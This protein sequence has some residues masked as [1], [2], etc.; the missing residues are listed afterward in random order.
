LF[1]V[2]SV[3]HKEKRIVDRERRSK[4]YRISSYYIGKSLAEIPLAVI[5][6]VIFGTVCYWLIGLNPDPARFFTF[7]LILI[8]LSLVS[9]S[10][11]IAISAACPS[12][13]IA[14]AISPM[15]ITLFT[16]FSG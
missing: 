3:F 7:L 13:D 16:L 10:F 4:M 12:Y 9:Q 14:F 5:F 15:V 8:L 2:L 11:G 6:P 1:A